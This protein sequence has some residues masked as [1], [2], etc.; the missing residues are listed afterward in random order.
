M[1]QSIYLN[2]SNSKITNKD[3]KSFVLATNDDRTNNIFT[4]FK[5]RKLKTDE[6][7]IIGLPYHLERLRENAKILD[8]SYST[9][10]VKDTLLKSIKN[11]FDSHNT[12][13]STKVRIVIKKE[14]QEIFISEL[15][16]EVE[17]NIKLVSIKSERKNPEIKSTNLQ[18]CQSAREYAK[19][20]KASEALLIDKD[21]FVRE[22]S[23]SNFF[24]YNKKNN[25]FTI[26]SK[27]LKGV[28]RK[29]V[30]ENNNVKEVDIKYPELLSII[31]SGFITKSTTGISPVEMLDQKQL[32]VKQT[33]EIAK[34]YQ[35]LYLSPENI[36]IIP[37]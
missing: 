25:L 10:L 26:K 33:E 31:S 35:E 24:W 5:A 4:T 22:G 27:I 8:I 9:E 29:I 20:S 16:E 7:S 19:N 15:S 21:N 28:T 1:D 6:F 37:S 23:Y 17:N 18:I 14:E 3:P 36:Y 11:Y 13:V 34:W 12:I 30:L 2:I 32:N